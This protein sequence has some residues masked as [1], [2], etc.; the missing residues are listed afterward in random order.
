MNKELYMFLKRKGLE[1]CYAG[2]EPML[3]NSYVDAKY[4]QEYADIMSKKHELDIIRKFFPSLK[5]RHLQ[6]E[7]ERVKKYGS[8]WAN[9]GSGK[10][11]NEGFLSGYNWSKRIFKKNL[12]NQK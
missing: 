5:Q 8:S 10:L 3:V 4:L 12:E 9:T 1:F 7:Y 2:K 11:F 6:A